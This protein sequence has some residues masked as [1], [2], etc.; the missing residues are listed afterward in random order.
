MTTRTVRQEAEGL[1]VPRNL[2]YR[3]L[4]EL[5]WLPEDRTASL[6]AV[7]EYVTKEANRAISWYLAK[8]GAKRR[9][10]QVLRLAAIF[11]TVLAGVIPLVA[12]ITEQ[13]DRVAIAPG[14]AS[15]A[16]VVAAACVGLDRYFGYSS[17]WMRFLTTEMKI[18]CVLHEF[19]LKWEAR[20]AGWEG[21]QP[22][23]EEVQEALD[24]CRSFLADV[25][26]ILEKEMHTWVKEFS[27]ALTEVDR[28][29]K[30]QRK[31]KE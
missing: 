19:R 1:K 11:A 13:E 8:K 4:P 2:D 18:R 5:S 21:D 9:G 31:R 17:A 26:E 24:L 6:E 20:R 22:A 28:A 23:S 10:A 15:V 29:S 25:D 30:V 14:W 7:A 16:L 3:P 27:L 12:Q